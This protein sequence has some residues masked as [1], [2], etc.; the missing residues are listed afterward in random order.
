MLIPVCHGSKMLPCACACACP[1]PC[2]IHCPIPLLPSSFPMT[3]TMAPSGSCSLCLLHRGPPLILIVRSHHVLRR[4]REQ[5]SVQALPFLALLAILGLAALPAGAVPSSSLECV[6]DLDLVLC[7]TAAVAYQQQQQHNGAK[8]KW[9]WQQQPGTVQCQP[10]QP[11]QQP[12]AVLR[13]IVVPSAG[14]LACWRRC[15]FTR[16]CSCRQQH[17][18]GLDSSFDRSEGQRKG[19]DRGNTGRGGAKS[20]QHG[21]A[22]DAILHEQ[23]RAETRHY[24]LVSPGREFQGEGAGKGKLRKRA[25][26]SNAA[27]A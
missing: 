14:A 4:S 13:A 16:C 11:L 3:T 7:P 12:F 23:F 8:G 19:Q 21:T 1:C 25:L 10:A 17:Q 5:P 9:C 6:D 15:C 26:V 22:V 27:L 24:A 18:I 20:R 2:A